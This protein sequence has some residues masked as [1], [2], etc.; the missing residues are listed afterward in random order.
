MSEALPK[1]CINAALC[2]IT[3]L[4]RQNS[5]RCLLE[6]S[7]S[8]AAICDMVRKRDISSKM[9]GGKYLRAEIVHKKGKQLVSDPIYNKGLAFPYSERD[10]LSIRGL[11]PPSV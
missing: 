8:P 1:I 2:H 3:T 6:T 9:I 7:S 10:R 4:I 11:M 5:L